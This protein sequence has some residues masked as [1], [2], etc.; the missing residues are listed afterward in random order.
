MNLNSNQIT[1]AWLNS[2]NGISNG[3][4]EKLIDYFGSVKDIWDNFE[5]EK[6]N[7]KTLNLDTI[8]KLIKA[9][10]N[11]VELLEKKLIEENV[12][13]VTYLDKD[14]PEKLKNI[15][16]A[17]VLL[18]YKGSLENINN[19]SIAIVGSRK[20]TSYGKWTAEKFTKELSELGVTIISGL[21][22]GIDT[23][24]HHSAIKYNAKT[25]G[26]IGCGINIVYPKRNENLYKEIIEKDGAVIT[27][28]PFNMQPM[29]ANFPYRNR[30]ISG[31]SDGIL[32]IEAQEKSGTLITA[33]HGANQGKE[34]FAVPGNIDSL[35]SKGT[36]SLIKDGAKMV[37]C[38]DDIIEEI[39]ELKENIKKKS[40]IDSEF[41]TNELKIVTLL[42]TGEKSIDEIINNTDIKVDEILC[43]LTILEIKGIIKQNSYNKYNIYI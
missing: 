10:K 1:L 21:A 36:N 20:S 15:D 9:K 26:V 4:I 24:A 25:I 35:Y 8:N 6:G 7:I 39:L 40:V 2:F 33:G 34:I 17:P 42:K 38:I 37:T 12:S 22:T 16:R 30:I 23:I 29:P 11:F 5:S 3:K 19:L 43:V 31:L 14:Y 28:Y 18:Y 32:V 27:E 41:S 13:I